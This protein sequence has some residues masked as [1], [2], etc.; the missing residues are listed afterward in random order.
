MSG[1]GL[2]IQAV[3]EPGTASE[4]GLKVRVGKGEETLVGYDTK[5]GMVFVDRTRSG[6][7]DF[8]PKFADRHSGPLAAQPGRIRL[9][10]FVDRSSV[11]AFAGEGETVLTDLIFPSS[12]SQGLEL[13]ASGGSAKLVRLDV[14]KLRSIWDETAP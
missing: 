8:H 3:F 4:F 14:W 11:E 10:I 12:A 2:E 7:S 13:F 6:R 9:H 5:R 1:K